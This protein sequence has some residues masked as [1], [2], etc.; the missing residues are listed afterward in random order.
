MARA[1]CKTKRRRSQYILAPTEPSSPNT[2]SPGYPKSPKAHD[3]DVKSY[4]M[5][6]KES[7]KEDINNSL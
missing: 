6:I 1:K 3:V 4:L 2:A 7:F 5:K